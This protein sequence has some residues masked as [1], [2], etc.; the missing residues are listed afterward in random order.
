MKGFAPHEG[1]PFIFR[2]SDMYVTYDEDQRP[3][4]NL[5]YLIEDWTIV[6]AKELADEL[7]A[8]LGANPNI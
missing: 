1:E 3:M 8:W 5:N 2:N 6:G 7:I 4:I